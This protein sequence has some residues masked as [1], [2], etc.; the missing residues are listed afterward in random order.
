MAISNGRSSLLVLRHQLKVRTRVGDR[1]VK[2]LDREQ[3]ARRWL[4]FLSA[5][6]PAEAGSD[7]RR[8]P[9]SHDQHDGPVRDSLEVE[10]SPAGCSQFQAASR[11]RREHDHPAE[12]GSRA[13]ATE[14]PPSEWAIRLG[15]TGGRWHR[16]PGRRPGQ[17]C[18]VPVLLGAEPVRG[19]P[20]C[21]APRLG[22][23]ARAGRTPVPSGTASR[24]ARGAAAPGPG[25]F[26]EAPRRWSCPRRRFLASGALLGS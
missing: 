24:S 20:S 26:G 4:R 1:W 14:R 21:P 3:R 25:R 11:A 23:R 9:R 15:A 5:F 12:P 2:K 19:R 16:G 8:S 13:R 10:P 22:T 18:P 7:R 17:R 6:V